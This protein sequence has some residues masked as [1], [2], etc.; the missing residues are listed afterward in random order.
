MSSVGE[1][2]DGAYRLCRKRTMDTKLKCSRI[3]IILIMVSGSG[4]TQRVLSIF[5]CALVTQLMRDE[6]KDFTLVL[7]LVSLFMFPYLLARAR[8]AVSATFALVGGQN[9]HTS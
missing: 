2:L 9:D 3:V 7:L 6:T 5:L 8:V 1:A 4:I